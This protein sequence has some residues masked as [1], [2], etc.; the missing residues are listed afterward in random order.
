MPRDILH[1]VAGSDTPNCNGVRPHFVL[2]EVRDDF[3]IGFGDEFVAELLQLLLQVEVVFDD[4]VVHHHDLASA[5][6]V[7]MS[8]LFGRTPMR[9]PSRVADA[10]NPFERLR[11]DGVLEVDEL[12]RAPSPLNLSVANDGNTCRVVAAVF[13]PPEPVDEDRHHFFRAEIADDSAHNVRLPTLSRLPDSSTLLD[14]PPSCSRP[15][16]R[17]CAACRRSPRALPQARP[18]E[19]WRRCRRTPLCRR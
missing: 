3:G 19:A 15:S 17:C 16:L 9:G 8:V 7:R 4:A 13:K 1:V 2:D 5:V 18:R 12:A 10:V 14:S 6:L 11:V